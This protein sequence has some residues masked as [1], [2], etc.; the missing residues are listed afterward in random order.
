MK[1]LKT[2]WGMAAGVMGL[3]AGRIIPMSGTPF[4]N[5]VQDMATLMTFIDPSA[6]SAGEKW[7]KENTKNGEA[8]AV[9]E[10]VKDWSDTYLLRRDKNVISAHLPP[11]IIKSKSVLPY[12]ME[13]REYEK[14][15][16]SFLVILSNFQT[17]EEGYMTPAQKRH[18][19]FLKKIMMAAATCS[20]FGLV[21][22]R[23]IIFD[24]MISLPSCISLLAN[25]Y[26]L[27]RPLILRSASRSYP[28]RPAQ[29]WP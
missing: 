14:H 11:K 9:V 22:D 8:K 24:L 27:S 19:K 1:S 20:K 10:A 15:E 12:P 5:N 25:L 28:S 6:G 13:L 29:W 2:Y 7:W 18:A 21:C 16:E 23:C 17:I 26:H 4:N 3:H